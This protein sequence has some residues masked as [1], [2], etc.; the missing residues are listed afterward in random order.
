MKMKYIYRFFSALAFCLVVW[1]CG[2]EEPFQISQDQ[3]AV[4]E[5]VPR[6]LGFNN[7][8]VE[9]KS[10]ADDFEKAI[11]NCFFLLFDNESGNILNT[12][13]NLV[14]GT[15]TTLPTQLVKLDKVNATSV[16]ACFIANVPVDF[17]TNIIGLNRPEGVENNEANNN[18]YLNT[19]VLSGIT[20]GTGENFGIPFIDLDGATGTAAAVA[21]I[22]MFGKN[23]ITLPSSSQKIQIPLKRLFAKVTM[24]IKMQLTNVGIGQIAPTTV[25]YEL[26]QYQLHSLPTKVRLRECECEGQCVCESGWVSDKSAFYGNAT[27]PLSSDY[28]LGLQ[29]INISD[30]DDNTD[31]DSSVVGGIEFSFYVPEYYLL[32]KTGATQDQKSKPQNYDGTKCPVYVKLIG[33]VNRSLIDNTSITHNIYLG[34]DAIDDFTLIR[35]YNYINQITIYGIDDNLDHRV[36]A[37]IINNPVAK[38]GQSANCYII[39]KPGKYTIP[40]YKGAYTNLNE[41]LLCMV[42]KNINEYETRVKVLANVVEYDNLT[43]ITFS[44][45]EEPTYDSETNTISFTVNPM[46]N[47]NWVPNGSV[48]IALQYR[49]KGSTNEDDWITE[50]SWHLWFVYNITAAEDGWGT[51]GYQTMPD[52]TTKMMD[53]NLGVHAFTSA[54]IDVGFYYKS[55]QKEPFVDGSYKGGGALYDDEGNPI[56]HSWSGNGKS[57]TDPCPPGYRV[58]SEEVW[59]GTNYNS[60]TLEDAEFEIASLGINALRYWDLNTSSITDDIYYPYEGSLPSSNK[61]SKTYPVFTKSNEGIIEVESDVKYENYS[62]TEQYLG[63]GERD[64]KYTYTVYSD[65]SYNITATPDKVGQLAICEQGK[66]L[67]YDYVSVNKSTFKNVCQF[68]KCKKTVYDVSVVEIGASWIWTERPSTRKETLKSSTYIYN[69]SELPADWKDELADS[70]CTYDA[71]K[72]KTHKEI[73]SLGAA[74][75]GDYGYQVRCVK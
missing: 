73:I 48:I 59:K 2:L 42:G 28:N 14:E 35:N 21:C 17:V 6:A 69:V 25:N 23:E 46:L 9:T 45:N 33:E 7:Q 68:V 63:V 19:A 61:S 57:P 55:G 54:G 16:T 43:S 60:A 8:T 26:I 65:F 4:I 29:T 58:P 5:F 47:N 13:V 1:A 22:P 53:R 18:K 31:N 64:K 27:S 74:Q 11:H 72:V 3:G 15:A 75:A 56:T 49:S 30:S 52:G 67:N 20:Y 62:T 66:V 34:R 10:V 71:I 36:T 12:P 50:W 38:A 70:E 41:A 32:P 40:A 51:I 44:E 39:A 37:E 24:N